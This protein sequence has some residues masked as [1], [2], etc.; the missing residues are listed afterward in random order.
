PGF[1]TAF[2]EQG[3][4]LAL[5]LMAR[6]E[7][8][9]DEPV[10]TEF[11]REP[12]R[13]VVMH[14]VGH[15]LG[16]QHNF[17]SSASTPL[18]RLHDREW[19]AEHGVF[20]SVM[21]YPTVNIA[22]P[23]E[24]NGHYY[25]PGPGS[26]DRW[27]VSYAYSPDPERAAALARQAADPRHMYG[28]ETNAFDPSINTYDLS[29]DPIGWATQRTEIAAGLW[30]RLTAYAIADDDSYAE[31]TGAFQSVLRD[32]S[33][34]LAPAV[35]FI[36]G[37]YM[38]R[39]HVGDPDGRLPFENVPVERQRAALDLIVERAFEADAFD[40]PRDVIERL[41]A[42]HWSH[43]GQ[44]GGG[45]GGRPDFSLHDEVLDLQRSILAQ[46][47][48]PVRLARVRDGEA[49]FGTEAV[50]TIPELFGELRGAVWAEVESASGAAAITA[51]RRDLQRA[52]L[53]ALIGLVVDPDDRLPAD[54]RSVAR[55]ELRDLGETIRRR[56]DAGTSSM[57]TYTRAHLDEAAARI[58][59]ALE[60]SARVAE[61]DEG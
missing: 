16:L 3:A 1:A 32:Y 53:D 27:A 26:Y 13:W 23:G 25:N 28:N 54:A 61:D 37:Q 42:N 33:R 29:A 6:G 2:I 21:E 9:P 49:R 17:R 31:L 60:A 7:I 52:H 55:L 20:S 50:V 39:D 22:P 36:G 56:L 40:V 11:L 8:D 46:L 4:M 30:Q 47:H 10:P 34:A 41:G 43:W 38:N 57:D 14:E 5:S 15:T 59:E 44:G 51:M 18:D 19:T 45:F 24:E 48:H 58:D 12:A 35:K